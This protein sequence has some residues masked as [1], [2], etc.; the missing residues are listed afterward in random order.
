[1]DVMPKR[2]WIPVF[3][4]YSCIF[5]REGALFI[6]GSKNS[7]DAEFGCLTICG[8]TF[9]KNNFNGPSDWMV[10]KDGYITGRGAMPPRII[11]AYLEGESTKDGRLFIGQMELID[12]ATSDKP[13]SK[14]KIDTYEDYQQGY[15]ITLADNKAIRETHTWMTMKNVGN[16]KAGECFKI[17]GAQD[18]FLLTQKIDKYKMALVGEVVK[19]DPAV[20]K[21]LEQMGVF[22]AAQVTEGMQTIKRPYYK[23]CSEL[24]KLPNEFDDFN[25][26]AKAID[27]VSRGIDR[28]VNVTPFL[29]GTIEATDGLLDAMCNNL[30]EWQSLLNGKLTEEQCDKLVPAV[31]LLLPVEP[32]LTNL[33]QINSDVDA[34]EYLATMDGIKESDRGFVKTLY[35]YNAQFDAE[36]VFTSFCNFWLGK[37]G[38]KELAADMSIYGMNVNDVVTIPWHILRGKAKSE[39]ANYFMFEGLITPR[40]DDWTI[41]LPTVLN[42]AVNVHF[43]YTKGLL[44]ESGGLTFARDCNSLVAYDRNGAYLWRAIN[45]NEK[46]Y[47][48]G[49]DI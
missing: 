27:V 19:T 15:V 4:K 35:A 46:I 44:L 24:T 8:D 22:K 10:V 16:I 39:I 47:L 26:S 33:N 3:N 14:H 28:G 31:N 13:L 1:M 38:L 36:D 32:Y 41:N 23:D 49:I 45:V 48:Y 17:I 18:G 20:F 34:W 12:K 6:Y 29:K 30:F 5:Y 37:L 11:E 7:T 2:N 9:I 43:D 40:G 42:N 21:Q 25:L